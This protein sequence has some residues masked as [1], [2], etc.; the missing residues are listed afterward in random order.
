MLISFII[1]IDSNRSILES[2]VTLTGYFH[3]RP[4]S[5]LSTYYLFVASFKSLGSDIFFNVT[6]DIPSLAIN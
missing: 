5:K 4:L 2:D 1:L 3:L 6:L